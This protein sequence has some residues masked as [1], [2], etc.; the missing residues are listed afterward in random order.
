MLNETI[1]HDIEGL[2]ESEL[3]ASLATLSQECPEKTQSTST[4]HTHTG[5]SLQRMNSCERSYI[6][7]T[8]HTV[9]IAQVPSPYLILEMHAQMTLFMTSQSHAGIRG[10]TSVVP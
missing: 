6:P 2:H 7:V 5:K 8:C 9:I 1:E 10:I 4:E 3:M